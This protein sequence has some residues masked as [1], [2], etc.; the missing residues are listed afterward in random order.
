MKIRL[1][2]RSL[3]GRLVIILVT[4]LIL[5]Q[6]ASVVVHWQDRGRVLHRAG[7]MHFVERIADTVRLLDQLSGNQRLRALEALNR[8]PLRVRLFNA[9][10]RLETT[11]S[12]QSALELI[13]TEKLRRRLD[14]PRPARVLIRDARGTTLNLLRD[15]DAWTSELVNAGRLGHQTSR[16]LLRRGEAMFVSRVQLI[17]GAW[18]ELMFRPPPDALG[19]LYRLVISIALLVGSVLV[20]ALIAVRITT[21]P[22]SLLMGQ[23]EELG[24]DIHRPP[25]PEGG[26]TEVQGAA[27][28]LNTLQRRVQAF[29]EERTRLL[30][31]V[32]HDL[33][34]PITRMRLRAEMLDDAEL[35]QKFES[36]LNEMDHMVNETLDLVR[37]VDTREPRQA[38]DIAALLESLQIDVQERGRQIGLDTKLRHPHFA[39]PHALKRCLMNLIENALK[40]GQH[41]QISAI[42][43]D[44]RLTIVVSDD[45]PGI[46]AADLERVFEPYYRVDDSRSRTTGGTGLGLAIARSVAQAHGG[47]IRLKNR[48]S[49]GVEA[50]LSLPTRNAP[51]RS[52]TPNPAGG[53]KLSA[54][55]II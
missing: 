51:A 16:R 9:D 19:G 14:P 31:A 23:A 54:S 36:D 25:L 46:P 22:L 41:V 17:D 39:Q 20:L 13:L 34:T 48:V 50:V 18:V 1:W 55:S 45:G 21:R 28:A 3:F 27:R 29:L 52:D 47:D 15:N 35:R 53:A 42:D 8:A 30:V 4:G 24:R 26:P 5:A 11:S 2:P 38:I 12:G 32:S 44:Q 10:A 40:Y 33:K 37:D 6:I 43:D 7:G 49:G